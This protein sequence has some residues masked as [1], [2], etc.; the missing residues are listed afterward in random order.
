MLE[1]RTPEKENYI[2][3]LTMF[4]D[5]T[6]EIPKISFAMFVPVMKSWGKN[7][8]SERVSIEI[9]KDKKVTHKVGENL[10][11]SLVE[12]QE[13]IDLL[14]VILG[15]PTVATKNPIKP[16]D[17]L[18]IEFMNLTADT[19]F[20]KISFNAEEKIEGVLLTRRLLSKKMKTI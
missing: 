20:P 16:K 6:K 12:L 2:K 1:E 19:K 8:L 3:S 9:S 11:F 13:E 5:A 15:R 4:F 17:S 10:G 14:E 7:S 18:S